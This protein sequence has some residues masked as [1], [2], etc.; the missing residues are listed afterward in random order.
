MLIYSTFLDDRWLML[1]KAYLLKY[2]QMKLDEKRDI[3]IYI[4]KM[5]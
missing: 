2:N 1:I 3:Y 5:R 4:C